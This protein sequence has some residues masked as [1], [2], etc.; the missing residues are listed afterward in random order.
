MLTKLNKE[1]LL[2]YRKLPY[3]IYRNHFLIPQRPYFIKA[4]SLIGLNNNIIGSFKS[5]MPDMVN[6]DLINRA[7]DPNQR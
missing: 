3:I 2:N 6:V 7:N 1:L 5:L 4:N